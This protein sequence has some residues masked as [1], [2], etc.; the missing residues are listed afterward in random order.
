M[1]LIG[2]GMELIDN[3]TVARIIAEM[4]EL[5]RTLKEWQTI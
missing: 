3:L 4:M 1:N 5:K 2:N